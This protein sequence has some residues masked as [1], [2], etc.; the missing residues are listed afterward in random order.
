MRKINIDFNKALKKIL[1]GY[2]V[3]FL[4]GIAFIFVPGFGVKLDINFGGGTKIAY[5]YTGD[6]NDSDIESTVKGVL[7]KSFT[8]SKSTSLAGDTKTFEIALVGKNSVSAEKQEELTKNLTDKFADNKI[9]LYN[10]NSV[11][12]TVAGSFFVKSMVAVVI[13]AVLVVIYVGIRFRKIGG[14]SAAVTALCAL[15]FDVLIT[16]FTCVFFKLQLDSNYIAVVLTILGY[17]LNDTIVIYDRVRENKRLMPDAEIGEVVNASINTTL[18]RNVITSLT[19]FV[20]VMTIVTVSELFGLSTLRT[21]AIPMAFGIISGAVT[22]LFVAGP[23]WV[24]WK[25]HKAKKAVAKKK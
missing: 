5:S 15:V 19:T 14:V 25:R 4:A 1:I 10:S 18:K 2:A 17:S 22:S 24:I 16:F 8:I 21:F 12:P 6:I 11:S 3:I 23:L 7:D 9:A 20:A 13:T